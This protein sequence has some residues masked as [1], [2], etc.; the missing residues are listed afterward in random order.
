RPVALDPA[1]IERLA[2]SLVAAA[3]RIG[4]AAG[5]TPRVGPAV[6]YDRFDLRRK[7]AA[8]D[9]AREAFDRRLAGFLLAV[10]GAAGDPVERGRAAVVRRLPPVRPH[11]PPCWLG[12]GDR[13]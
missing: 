5:G 12:S 1:A 10:G 11:G 6:P 7:I 3:H 13:G 4:A 8:L 2:E 9:E